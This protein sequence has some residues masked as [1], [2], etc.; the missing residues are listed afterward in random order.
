MDKL[1]RQKK[2]ISKETVDLGPGREEGR[3]GIQTGKEEVN[4]SL[5]QDDK[6]LYKVLKTPHMHTHT[7]VSTN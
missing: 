3:K 6:V 5:P 2:K 1:S 4:L 7:N